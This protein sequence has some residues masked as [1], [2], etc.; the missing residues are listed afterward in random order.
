[1]QKF[2]LIFDGLPPWSIRSRMTLEMTP[3]RIP[4]ATVANEN[5]GLDDV[6]AA[7]GASAPEDA[8]PGGFREEFG[9][10]RASEDV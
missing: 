7:I 6:T 5:P 2:L 9:G 4:A 3:R 1:L 10:G 8:W